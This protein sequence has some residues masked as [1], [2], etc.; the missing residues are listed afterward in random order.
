MKSYSKDIA[1][2]CIGYLLRTKE[3][4]NLLMK[5]EIISQLFSNVADPA[6]E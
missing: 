4:E 3:I 5:K 2:L 1:A 6:N